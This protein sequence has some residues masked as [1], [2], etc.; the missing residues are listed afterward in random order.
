MRPLTL[1]GVVLFASWTVFTA[2]ESSSN[3]EQQNRQDISFADRWAG[4]AAAQSAGRMADAESAYRQIFEDH[5][6]SQRAALRI[7]IVQGH[8]EKHAESHESYA[9]AYNVDPDGPWA[10]VT[11]FYWAR[12]LGSNGDVH[13]AFDKLDLLESS[14][15]ESSYVAQARLLRLQ[16]KGQSTTSAE[17]ELAR[18]LEAGAKYDAAV[19]KNAD[20]AINEL[21]S[22]IQDYPGTATELRAKES[23]G[24][25]LANAGETDDAIR[26]FTDIL[27]ICSSTGAEGSRLCDTAML[28]LGALMHRIDDRQSALDIYLELTESAGPESPI[29]AKAMMEASGIRFEILQRIPD[30]PVEDF[31]ELQSMLESTLQHPAL[32]DESRATALLMLAESYFWQADF[33]GCA[34]KVEEFLPKL[35]PTT[36]RR[37]MATLHFFAGFSYRMKGNQDA[38]LEHYRQIVSHYP[39]QEV[40]WPGMDHLERARFEI[41]SIRREQGAEVDELVE[42][43]EELWR[44]FPDSSYSLHLSVDE[45]IWRYTQ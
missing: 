41:F 42:L 11:L 9:E 22:I 13:A 18:E 10:P 21:Q 15:P 25:L 26:A 39:D 30:A 37:E 31:T 3:P 7:A 32:S 38:A 36:S 12:A 20:R 17:E 23:L 19:G 8:Q 1:A 14:H 29:G 24:N 34:D 2:G 6:Q 27:T 35:D 43:A 33:T 5:P 28:R 45:P 4:A 44:L 40:P 16:M